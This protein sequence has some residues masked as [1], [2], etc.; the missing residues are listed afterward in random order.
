MLRDRVNTMAYSVP[1]VTLGGVENE[2]WT[3]AAVP[4]GVADALART[5]ESFGLSDAVASTDTVTVAGPS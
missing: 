3:H 5:S 1:D 2:K 4:G